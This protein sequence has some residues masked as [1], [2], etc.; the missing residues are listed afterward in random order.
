MVTVDLE[1]DQRGGSSGVGGSRWYD[2]EHPFRGLLTAF[3]IF[4]RSSKERPRRVC[5]S[6]SEDLRAA[7][8]ARDGLG[9][10]SALVVRRLAD[11]WLS[12][13]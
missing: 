3:R 10:V 4:M 13:C 5:C 11:T 6:R 9:V 1:V 12:F 2:F 8:V 7:V